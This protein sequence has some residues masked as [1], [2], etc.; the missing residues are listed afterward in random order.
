MIFSTV[1]CMMHR[2]DSVVPRPRTA[3]TTCI[4]RDV[5]RETLEDMEHMR[6]MKHQG[7]MYSISDYQCTQIKENPFTFLTSF[8]T[9]AYPQFKSAFVHRFQKG[10]EDNVHLSQET[11]NL[12]SG[13]NT[14]DSIL[15]KCTFEQEDSE[16]I[17]TLL[18]DAILKSVYFK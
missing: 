16:L 5:V 9:N 4:T 7:R 10:V 6:R 14:F 17:N 1:M 13:R 18:K 2:F 11:K 12:Y 15:H 3:R 8:P